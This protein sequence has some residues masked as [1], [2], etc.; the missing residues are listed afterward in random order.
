[1]EDKIMG[2]YIETPHHQ[3][4]AK[5]LYDLYKAELVL[6]PENFDFASDD[7]LI[8]V[9]ENT[10][11][12]AAAIAYDANERDQFLLPDFRERTWLK[13]PKKLVCELCPRVRPYLDPN[14][15]PF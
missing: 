6:D 14:F 5:Q 9:V 15:K 12:D 2:Y 7:A 13:L 11:F 8:C 10:N 4:K 1:V 3:N